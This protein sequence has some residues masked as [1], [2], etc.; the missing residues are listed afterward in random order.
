[1]AFGA[2]IRLKPWNGANHAFNSF[3]SLRLQMPGRLNGFSSGSVAASR[4]QGQ[5]QSQF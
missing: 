4:F 5:Q 2:S 3:A 1:M